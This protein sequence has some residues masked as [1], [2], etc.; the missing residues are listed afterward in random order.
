MG[1]VWACQLLV[2]QM[3]GRR[4]GCIINVA[5]LMAAKGGRGST[6]Y[7]ASKGAT[8]GERTSCC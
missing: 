3:M 6:V 4:G 5:S 8:V 1:S 7:A 2:R